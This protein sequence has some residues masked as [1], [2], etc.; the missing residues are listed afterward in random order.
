MGMP[1]NREAHLDRLRNDNGARLYLS[2]ENRISISEPGQLGTY[3]SPRSL[4]TVS[5]R[6]LFTRAH[7]RTYK[8]F[9][10]FFSGNPRR[11]GAS[12]RPRGAIERVSD[13]Q[14]KLED[15]RVTREDRRKLLLVIRVATNEPCSLHFP[16]VIILLVISSLF[17]R[18][19]ILLPR[20]WSALRAFREERRRESQRRKGRNGEKEEG[21][22]SLPRACGVSCMAIEQRTYLVYQNPSHMMRY[23]S[24]VNVRLLS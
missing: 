15:K 23:Y 21:F 2:T 9:R 8:I 13:K 4:P 16:I 22:K 1:G 3:P 19:A 7:I 18:T 14:E 12:G 5:P 24:I 11:S 17:K 20:C 10:E 6:A